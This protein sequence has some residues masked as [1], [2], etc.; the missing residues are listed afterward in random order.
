MVRR[1]C[2]YIFPVFYTSSLVLVLNNSVPVAKV[3]LSA[4]QNDISRVLHY[5]LVL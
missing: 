4:R 1:A 2:L 5:A 3:T